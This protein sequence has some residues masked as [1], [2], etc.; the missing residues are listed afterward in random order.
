MGL[1]AADMEQ[2]RER[3]DEAGHPTV[4]SDQTMP[5]R[6]GIGVRVKRDVAVVLRA[7]GEQARE[8]RTHGQGPPRPKCPGP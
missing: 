4:A 7:T 6:A 3:I 5:D 1:A 8:A 2:R